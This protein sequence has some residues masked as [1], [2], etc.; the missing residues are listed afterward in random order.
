M[1]IQKGAYYA[2]KWPFPLSCCLKVVQNVTTVSYLFLI[3]KVQYNELSW[4]SSSQAV[5]LSC[6]TLHCYLVEKCAGLLKFQGFTALL[7]IEPLGMLC[8]LLTSYVDSLAHTLQ[9]IVPYSI[10]CPIAYSVLQRIASYQHIAPY[11]IIA[12]ALSVFLVWSCVLSLNYGISCTDSSVTTQQCP[13]Q[14]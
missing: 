11:S 7:L 3:G 10:Q 4:L 12:H 5:S 8:I 2:P 14:W 6:D 9:H 13:L 1:Q